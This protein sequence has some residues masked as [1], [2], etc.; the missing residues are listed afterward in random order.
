MVDLKGLKFGDGVVIVW[1]D[2]SGL[3]GWQYGEP[4]VQT[5]RVITKG[6]VV[7]NDGEAIVV[8]GTVVNKMIRY[9]P[10]TIPYGA[11]EEIELDPPDHPEQG[12]E[13]G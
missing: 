7:A 2:S 10:L 12:K 8:T 4:R 13:G 11:I 6:Y 3:D 1:R 9:A 5:Q